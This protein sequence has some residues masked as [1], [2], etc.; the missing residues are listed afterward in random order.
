MQCCLLKKGKADINTLDSNKN[1]ARDIAILNGQYEIAKNISE[2]TQT[3][4]F[5][6][7]C[8]ELNASSDL[9]DFK[10]LCHAFSTGDVKMIE[11]ILSK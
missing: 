1:T 9:F 4:H 11:R 6:I 2:F 5:D 7:Q 8:T 10:S 3:I